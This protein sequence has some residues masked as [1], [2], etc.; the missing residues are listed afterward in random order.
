MTKLFRVSIVTFSLL[1]AVGFASL[2]ISGCGK[3]HDPVV[4]GRDG[5]E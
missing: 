4:F 5:G 2:A 3:P 1:I